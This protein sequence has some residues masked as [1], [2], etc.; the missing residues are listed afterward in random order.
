M[1]FPVYDDD[2]NDEND[3]K[4]RDPDLDVR[5]DDVFIPGPP[6][7]AFQTETTSLARNQTRDTIETKTGEGGACAHS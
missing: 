2:N 4:P 3:V 1:L 7:S 6:S 5:P